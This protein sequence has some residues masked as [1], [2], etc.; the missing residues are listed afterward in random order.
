MSISLIDK[1]AVPL[2]I[3]MLF[4]F[5][6]IYVSFHRS[7]VRVCSYVCL[8]EIFLRVADTAGTRVRYFN[9]SCV[10]ESEL[11]TVSTFYLH[12]LHAD[13]AGTRRRVRVHHAQDEKHLQ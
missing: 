9:C 1:G 8:R 5:N 11:T 10:S 13:T 2:Y 12:T 3:Q 7:L 4:V 6:Y